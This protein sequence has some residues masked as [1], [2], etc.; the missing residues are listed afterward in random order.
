M[1]ADLGLLYCALFWGVSFVTMKILVGIYPACWL[2]FLRFSV[3]SVLLYVF[4]RKRINKTFF[5]ELKGGAVIGLLLF[6]AIATQTVG[7]NYIGGGRSAF[8][9]ATYVLMVPMII[10][11]MTREFPGWLKIFAAVLCV[12]GMYF[13]TGDDLSK[14]SNL[15]DIL[16]VACAFMFAIQVLAISRL[17]QDSDPIV[18]SFTEF[19]SFSVFALTASML[20]ETRK[21][22]IDIP[23][24]PELLF[25]II[26]AT[27]GCYV[28][29]ICAQKYAEPS[30]ATIIMSLESVFG[31]F[32][33]MI[34]LGESLTFTAGIGCALIFV[35]VLVSE[36]EPFLKKRA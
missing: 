23:S 7:L 1:L 20:F 22:L 28:M 5:R 29:Q 13:L 2:L 15:G 19:V 25:T 34:F 9:S 30:H 10:W 35:S 18:L 16:T 32:G 14:G 3:S 17:T 33:S 21:V 36:L 8:I 26:F 27:F 24:L 31:L 4:F 11:A 12:T 6:I